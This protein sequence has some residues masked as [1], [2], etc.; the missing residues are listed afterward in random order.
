[1]VHACGTGVMETVSG[2]LKTGNWK[3][4]T[5]RKSKVWETRE[6]SSLSEDDT[7]AGAYFYCL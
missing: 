3:K 4:D 7:G 6:T 1:M 2:K 5:D